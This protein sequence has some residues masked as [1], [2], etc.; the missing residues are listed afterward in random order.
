MGFPRLRNLREF[1]RLA[2]HCHLQTPAKYFI[3]VVLA[4]ALAFGSLGC[5]KSETSD[6]QPAAK[7]DTGDTKKDPTPS[8]K[9][10]SN[11]P[12]STT[13][14]EEEQTW[15]EALLEAHPAI[16]ALEK[17]GVKVDIASNSGLLRQR[18]GFIY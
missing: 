10:E 9:Q 8:E 3:G 2:I 5:K 18:P 7:P 1:Q 17:L 11:E 16:V 14:T 13:S 15:T 4:L 12:D 6:A